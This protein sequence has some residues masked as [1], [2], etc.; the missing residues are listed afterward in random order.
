[1]DF[2]AIDFETASEKHSSP[3]SLGI[4]I[5]KDNVIQD[6]RSYL[7][8]PETE[9]SPFNIAIHGI[10]PEDV[11]D[12]PSFPQI[13]S[14][15]APL[16]STFP[17]V[18]HNAPFER[19]VIEKTAKRYG[20]DLPQ[21]TYYC[22]LQLCRENYT[23]ERYTLDAI[24]KQMGIELCS[25]HSCDSD[26]IA[27]AEI[28][29]RLVSDENSNIHQLYQS[30]SSFHKATLK[31]P[32]GSGRIDNISDYAI[33]DL[34]YSGNIDFSQKNVVITGEIPG[35]TRSA[36]SQY[37]ESCGGICKTSVSRKTNIV[38]VGL[39]KTDLVTDKSTHKSSK[40]L[41]AEELI[42]SGYDIQFVSASN[43]LNMIN[44]SKQEC[45]DE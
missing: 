15:I 6:C 31:F 17:V 25:H 39:E 21:I 10:H 33:P 11:V 36:V 12:S 37:I 16:L 23:F 27:C 9:F 35:V 41:K 30:Y 1:M 3:C 43:I 44:Q 14:E 7:I 5:V 40:I 24:C 28:M 26:S 22:T 38:I 34:K 13:W 32:T 20:I 18:A 45:N 42:D 19:N 2:I 8:N 4:T 29:L